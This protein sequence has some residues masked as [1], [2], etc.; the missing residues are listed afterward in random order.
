MTSL[1][2]MPCAS[3][4]RTPARASER[5]NEAIAVPASAGGVYE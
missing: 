4:M 5:V 1:G 3:S 2:Y